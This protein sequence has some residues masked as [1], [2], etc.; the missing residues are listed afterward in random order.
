MCISEEWSALFVSS[1]GFPN[2][3]Y[4]AWSASMVWK[5]Q[6]SDRNLSGKVDWRFL[7]IWTSIAILFYLPSWIIFTVSLIYCSAS[8][9]ACSSSRRSSTWSARWAANFLF[10]SVWYCSVPLILQCP[11]APWLGCRSPRC[12][13]CLALLPSDMLEWRRYFPL[14]DCTCIFRI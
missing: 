7:L 8:R 4:K 1:I 6:Y 10:V 12:W 13:L 11:V 3:I 5:W 9:A 14:L 2:V